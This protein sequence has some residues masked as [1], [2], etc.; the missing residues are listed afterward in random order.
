MIRATLVLIV[1]C[2]SC[3]GSTELGNKV[4]LYSDTTDVKVETIMPN[5]WKKYDVPNFGEDNILLLSAYGNK[6]TSQQLVVDVRKSIEKQNLKGLIESELTDIR[7]ADTGVHLMELK[8]ID[9]T[10]PYQLAFFDYYTKGYD[11]TYYSESIVFQKGER[12]FSIE[13][14]SKGDEKTFRRLTNLIREHL[15]Y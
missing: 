13:I 10:M 15:R 7:S 4:I 12:V 2:V 9:S 1:F 6:D 3:T 11:Y 14:S 8:V 5:D